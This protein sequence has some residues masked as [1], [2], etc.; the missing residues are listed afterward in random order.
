[1]D[2][3]EVSVD[4]DNRAKWFVIVVEHCM[5]KYIDY[6]ADKDRTHE[7]LQKHKAFFKKLKAEL[8][9]GLE[10]IKGFKWRS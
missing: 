1:M 9:I 8:A 10:S 4:E 5:I 6:S 2:N 7:N 3:G